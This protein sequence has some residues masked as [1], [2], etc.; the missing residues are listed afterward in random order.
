V[1]KWRIHRRKVKKN[2]ESG[3][4]NKTKRR[5]NLSIPEGNSISG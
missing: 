3:M 1:K 5:K 2:E 4:K